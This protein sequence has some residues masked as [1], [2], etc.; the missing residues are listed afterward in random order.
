MADRDRQDA[1]KEISVLVVD[2][3]AL[4]RQLLTDMIAEDPELHVA[5][6]ARDGV[7]AIRMT[8]ELDPDVVTMDIH[9][10]EMDGISALEYIMKKTPRPVIMLSALAKKGAPPTLKALELGAVDFI[11]KP[12]QFPAS[13]QD[14]KED[15]I[16]KIADL[17]ENMNRRFDS[18]D[19]KLLEIIKLL[20]TPPGRR[21][22]WND[23][24][25]TTPTPISTTPTNDTP[26]DK[27]RPKKK[28]S[29]K[30]KGK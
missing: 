10:P 9:M 12:S 19:E 26:G 29:A 24:S 15:V 8:K 28:K 13:V 20:K 18:V 30:K 6:I 4:V 17:E 21:P 23:Q 16:E 7:E 27:K 5:G 1:G 22:G 14:I 11:A 25:F 3:S 2:D